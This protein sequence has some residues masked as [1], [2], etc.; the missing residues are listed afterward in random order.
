MNSATFKETTQRVAFLRR[1]YAFELTRHLL[2]TPKRSEINPLTW[3][4]GPADLNE[5]YLQH[6]PADQWRQIYEREKLYESD[7]ANALPL[8]EQ[9]DREIFDG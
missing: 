7:G 6:L 8:I 4:L 9:W 2:P 1:S 5:L 3:D